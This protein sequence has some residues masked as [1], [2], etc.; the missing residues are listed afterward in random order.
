MNDN[1]GIAYRSEPN[2]TSALI[3]LISGILGLTLLPIIGSIVA[4]IVGYMAKKEIRE[5]NGTVGGE[6]L[7]TTGIVLGWIGVGLTVV[8][9]CIAGTIFAIFG[10]ACLIPLGINWNQ[11]GAVLPLLAVIL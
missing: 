10:S 11:F 5:S 9:C 7:A 6:G 1:S 3:S 8:G 2:S 4:L